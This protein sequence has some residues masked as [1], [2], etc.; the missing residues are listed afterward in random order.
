MNV[1]NHENHEN[2]CNLLEIYIFDF[3]MWNDFFLVATVPAIY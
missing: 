1:T 2:A 3:E